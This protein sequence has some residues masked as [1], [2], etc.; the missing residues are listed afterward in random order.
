M[1]NFLKTCLFAAKQHHG[2]DQIIGKITKGLIFMVQYIIQHVHINQATKVPIW[3]PLRSSISSLF[4]KW[5]TYKNEADLGHYNRQATSDQILNYMRISL[6]RNCYYKSF[7]SKNQH[8][9]IFFYNPLN[10]IDICLDNR[11]KAL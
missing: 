7:F 11:G 2:I 1:Q 3:N 5:H 6:K 4:L 8:L 10:D 9:K